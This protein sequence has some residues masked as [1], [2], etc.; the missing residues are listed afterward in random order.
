[1]GQVAAAR[2]RVHGE[3]QRIMIIVRTRDSSY[4]GHKCLRVQQSAC[5]S[6]D[7]HLACHGGD[8]RQRKRRCSGLKL[9]DQ[10]RRVQFVELHNVP[11]AFLLVLASLAA[12][13]AQEQHKSDGARR[14]DGRTSVQ[15][16]PP[17]AEQGIL[18]RADGSVRF[19]MGNTSVLVAVY[20]PAQPV[21]TKKEQADRA[22]LEVT[23]KSEKGT[24]AWSCE[25]LTTHR[26]LLWN[27]CK[28]LV[29]SASFLAEIT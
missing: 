15:L 9:K 13:S 28:Q 19:M 29:V 26:T 23:W 27:W 20:G 21:S 18:N 1:M 8:D 16:R 11:T 24:F 10:K 6:C 2:L 22:S 25:R 14:P 5:S 7:E 17:V 4:H 3:K 12:M